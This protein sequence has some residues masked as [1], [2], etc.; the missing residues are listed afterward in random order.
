MIRF[1]SLLGS[2]TGPA[3][4]MVVVMVM[5]MVLLTVRKEEGTLA[6]GRA[7]GLSLLVGVLARLG[8]NLFNILLFQFM[9]P[10]LQDVYVDL[11]MDKS[12]EV[13]MAFG[14]NIPTGMHEVMEP[15]IRFSISIPG[16]LVD[17]GLNSIW[18]AFVALIVAAILKTSPEAEEGFN[19]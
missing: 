13:L 10:D 9:R 16:Q 17:A 2:W 8:Y 19:G 5:V 15:L 4:L 11:V 7:F 14:G 6:F 12:N 1:E 18:V 3:V